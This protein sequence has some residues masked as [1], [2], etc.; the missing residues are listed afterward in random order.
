MMSKLW[1]SLTSCV[2]LLTLLGIVQ[3]DPQADWETAISAGN[4]LHWYKFDETSGTD[5]IDSGSGQLNGTYD[6]PTP[7]QAGFFGSTSAATFT[8]VG[9]TN[10]AAFTGAANLPGP[11]TV[12]YVVMSTKA[13]AANDSMALHDSDTTS[14]RLAGWTSIGEVGFTLYGVADYQFTPTAGYTLQ[15][16]IAPQNEWIHLTFRNNGVGTQVFINGEMMGTSTDS[17]DLPRLRIGGRGAG[18]A[19]WLQGVLDEAVVYDRAL[20]DADILAHAKI[21][22]IA[23]TKARNP[24]PADGSLAVAMPL[25]QWKPGLGALLHNVYVGTSPELTEADLAA[26]KQPFAMLYYVQGFTPGATYYWRVDEF[27]AAGE[28]QTGNV[29][30]F[31]AQDLTAYYPAP[32]DGSNDA[33]QTLVLTWLPGQT[34]VKH[35]LYFGDSNDAVAQGAADVDKGELTDPTF[36]PEALESLTTYYWR[37]D[38]TVADGAVRTGPVWKFTT[39]MSVDDFESYT[40]DEGNRIYE[41]WIDGWTNGTGS[42]VGNA[43]APFAEQTIVNS[44]LQ[45]MP[46]DYNNVASPNYSEA[47]REF[48]PVQDWTVNGADTLVLSVRGRAGNAAA[49]LYVVVEDS[50]QNIGI[51]AYPDTSITTA[52][53]W[54]QWKIPLSSFAGV[55][56]AKVKKMYIDVGDRDTPVPGGAGRIYIDDIRVTRP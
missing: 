47:E 24:N 38:E 19:D 37:V 15:N 51:V 22:G 23:A 3:A 56:M 10:T 30:S 26:P 39:C 49:P 6:G 33:A 45:S 28:V 29:W 46:L 20:T 2:C 44:G 12:E 1:L 17:V 48:S 21:V 43:V 8:R 7:G 54:T 31:I 4:P 18:P 9:G 36:T 52:T 55:N 34:A 41:A 35:H 16:L 42:M 11:W 32:A 5:C 25:L 53:T 40:D 14:I 27:D 50:A 13:A